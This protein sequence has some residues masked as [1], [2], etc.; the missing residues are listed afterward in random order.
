MNDSSQ[1][2]LSLLKE[3][4]LAF[5]PPGAEGEVRQVVHRELATLGKVQHDALGSVIVESEGD[6]PRVVLDAH[7]DEVGFCVQSIDEEGRI[8]FVPLG[9]WWGHV[10]LAQ[11]VDILASSGQKI[12]GFIG[13]KP[14]HFLSPAERDKVLSL[15]QMYIDVGASD[16][17]EV[18]SWGVKVGDPIAPQGNFEEMASSGRYCCKAFDDRVGVGVMIESYRAAVGGGDSLRC[19]PIA[20]AAV[21]E[22]VGCRGAKTASA[23]SKP[24]LGI[25]LE[26]TPADDLPGMPRRQSVLGKGPQ[27]RFMDP[28]AISNRRL[29]RW[30]EAVAEEAGIPIQVAVRKSGGTDASTTHLHGSGVPTIVIGVPARSIHTHS[31]LIDFE[32]Y[33]HAVQL[34]T[35]MLRKLDEATVASFKSYE[36]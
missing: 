18:L 36:E 10:L 8:Y 11:R 5:G 24:D 28:T 27:I 9:G 3:L 13:C 25:I 21:Q 30:T 4:A 32:D 14:P 16:L 19:Q 33:Q 29:V 26:G 23:L 2:A 12:P 7:M 15:D 22:E 20:V 17:Q 6:G 1:A 34:V 35:A 31:S